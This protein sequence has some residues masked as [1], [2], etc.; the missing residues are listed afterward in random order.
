MNK[1]YIINTVHR[2]VVKELHGQIYW[3][4]ENSIHAQYHSQILNRIYQR[5]EKDNQTIITHSDSIVN[6][7]LIGI[8]RANTTKGRFDFCDKKDEYDLN[9]IV[10]LFYDQEG[11]KH[12]LKIE[13]DGRI[14][15]KPDGCFDQLSNDLRELF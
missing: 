8:K 13:T 1:L 9:R 15:N 10:F 12:E 2:K 11:I 7:L 3:F 14:Y 5:L 4:P 6:A